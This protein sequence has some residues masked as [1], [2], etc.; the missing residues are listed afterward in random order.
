MVALGGIGGERAVAA[1]KALAVR[2]TNIW[3]FRDT[4]CALLLCEDDK[5]VAY[6]HDPANTAH[7]PNAP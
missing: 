1:L 7:T 3:D 2:Q 4:Y 5:L 6:L